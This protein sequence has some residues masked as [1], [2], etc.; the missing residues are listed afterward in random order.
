MIFDVYLSR[1]FYAVLL[2]SGAPLLASACS[3]ILVAIIQTTTQI[4]EQTI[5]F[6]ARFVSVS[7]VLTLLYR[8][9]WIEVVHFIQEYLGS[10]A[11]LGRLT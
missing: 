7:A 5:S 8:W 9:Y 2:F 4:Q 11:Y 3:G 6:L 1:G 10:I